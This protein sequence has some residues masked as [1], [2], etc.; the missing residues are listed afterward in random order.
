M[1]GD[2]ETVGVFLSTGVGLTVPP[3]FPDEMC[4]AP[5]N[6]EGALGRGGGLPTIIHNGHFSVSLGALPWDPSLL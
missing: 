6:P 4:K 5:E 3:G 2:T 1:D